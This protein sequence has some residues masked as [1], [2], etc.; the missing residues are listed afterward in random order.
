MG[1]RWPATAFKTGPIFTWCKNCGATEGGAA[2]PPT[3]RL[4]MI[5]HVC[6]AA[7]C[8]VGLWTSA[9]SK[10]QRRRTGPTAAGSLQRFHVRH[11]QRSQRLRLEELRECMAALL[12]QPHSSGNHSAAWQANLH[13]AHCRRLCNGGA[14]VQGGCCNGSDVAC[15]RSTSCPVA[16]RQPAQLCVSRGVAARTR[17]RAWAPA[18]SQ[19]A[20]RCGAGAA[21]LHLEA[22]R[23]A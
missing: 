20:Q 15:P 1:G 23:L 7:L 4:L 3:R 8:F 21:Q 14:A 17:A 16:L 9:G 12:S 22:H 10:A 11:R 5:R 13:G 2:C 6:M 19:R 18:A